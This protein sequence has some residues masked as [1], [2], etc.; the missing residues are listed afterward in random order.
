MVRGTSGMKIERPAIHVVMFNLK[1]ILVFVK[2]PPVH[3]ILNL[4]L[5]FMYNLMANLTLTSYLRPRELSL[6]QISDQ[7]S[8]RRYLTVHR[9]VSTT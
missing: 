1:S 2:H 5:T 4:N 6:Q 8:L 3:V 7:R 9:G